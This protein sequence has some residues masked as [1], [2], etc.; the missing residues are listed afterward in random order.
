MAGAGMII[1]FVANCTAALAELLARCLLSL[2]SWQE[3]FKRLNRPRIFSHLGYFQY[4]S[5]PTL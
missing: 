1:V 5:T 4:R 2:P 3:S